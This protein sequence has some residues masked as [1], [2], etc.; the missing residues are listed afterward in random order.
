MSIM[1][2]FW[3]LVI[4]RRA[5]KNEATI[6]ITHTITTRMIV[7]NLFSSI[8]SSES[9]TSIVTSVLT[10]TSPLFELLE[11]IY[12]SEDEPPVVLSTPVESVLPVS[13]VV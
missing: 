11:S 1:T 3:R 8:P 6:T 7:K 2:F 4:I 9:V 12:V 10:T 13:T 5:R